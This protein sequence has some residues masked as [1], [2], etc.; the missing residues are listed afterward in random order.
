MN[1][2]KMF[3]RDALSP[4]MSRQPC[5]GVL[6]IIAHVLFKQF[7]LGALLG[8]LFKYEV[9]LWNRAPSSATRQFSA[10]SI[11]NTQMRKSLLLV[12]L[13][14]ENG[15]THLFRS[16]FDYKDYYALMSRDYRC[17]WPGVF[18]LNVC[19]PCHFNSG[20][21]KRTTYRLQIH[22]PF[23][24]FVQFIRS[25]FNHVA[26]HTYT[27]S[28]VSCDVLNR[29]TS[30]LHNSISSLNASVMISLDVD[31]NSFA[32]ST[33]RKN[34][35]DFSPLL[36]QNIWKENCNSGGNQFL[37]LIYLGKTHKRSIQ[38]NTSSRYEIRKQPA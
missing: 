15:W 21:I 30:A 16:N 31:R 9:W 25:I 37:V 33:R 36:H 38:Q 10:T 7:V 3:Q 13:P 29:T 6:W 8:F 20:Q 1:N 5:G 22:L 23:E 17:K 24:F 19:S 18:Y 34:T 11:L 2:K 4:L 14:G 26:H 32:K 12:L 28:L 35:Q 27:I